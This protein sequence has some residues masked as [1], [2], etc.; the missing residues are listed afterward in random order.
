MNGE[1]LPI[2]FGAFLTLFTAWS[3]GKILLRTYHVRLCRLEED[4]FAFL[5]GSACLSLVVFVLS[6]LH[7]AARGAF[8]ILCVAAAGLLY[9]RNGLKPARERLPRMPRAWL[10]LFVAPFAAY[11][12]LYFFNALAPQTNVGPTAYHLGNVMRWWADAGFDRNTGSAFRNLP[13]GLDML[14]LFAFSFGKH[15]AAVLV[16]FA[17]LLA[18]PWL[19]LCYGR[20]FGMVRPVVLGAMLVYLSPAAGI[21]GTT[22]SNEAAMTSVLFGLFYMLELWDASG[23]NRWLV[24]AGLLA[25]FGYAINYVAALGVLGSIAFVGWRVLRQRKPAGRALV[26]L[27]STAAISIAPW[28]LKNWL[29]AGDPFSPFFNSW[30]P[31]SNIHVWSEKSYATYL[32]LYSTIGSPRELSLLWSVRGTSIQG[33]F[34]PWLLLTPLAVL[35]VRWKHGRRLLL[36]GALFGLLALTDKAFA[37]VLPFAVFAAPA[38]GLAVQNSPGVLPLLL[39]LHSLAS[40]P[41]AVQRYADPHAWRITKIPIMEALRSVPEDAQLRSAVDGY[42]VARTIEQVTPERARILT[43]CPVP[44]AYTTRLLFDQSESAV[45]ELAYQSIMAVPESVVHPLL[46]MRFRFSPQPLRALRIVPTARTNDVWSVT[47]M[48]VYLAGVEISRRP[49]WRVSARPNSAEAPLAFDN[50]E[51][52]AWSTWQAT[53][54]GMFL[55]ED[56]DSAIPVDQAV[57]LGARGRG[58]TML[59]IDGLGNDGQWRM[60]AADPGMSL[61]LAPEG[62]RRVAV[63]E[64]RSLGFEYVVA[65]ND[66]APGQDMLRYASYWGMT[67]F[68]ETGNVCIFRLD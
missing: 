60:L 21:L 27:L 62:L 56:F 58:G 65:R 54:P 31:N 12:F 32:G 33:I 66:E 53:E 40:W 19:M 41:G 25:G 55:E 22:A 57:V 26:I 63:E 59:R 37:F 36:A 48:R 6:S 38:L 51:V 16:N 49:A 23:D 14:F 28:L 24:P 11:T 30:F 52:T 8:A 42:A 50:S 4:L 7:L 9:W 5:T 67:C 13:Q 18:L 64:L 10:F 47:E 3:L 34:G 35:A 2:F 15:S 29:W 46:E 17:F 1:L 43:L 20:R 45:G 68:K 44:Q 61:H 39:L